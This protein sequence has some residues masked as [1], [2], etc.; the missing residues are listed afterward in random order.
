MSSDP[1][2]IRP[3]RTED[4]ATFAR[5]V[6]ELGVDDPTPS[7]ERY[8]DEFRATMLIADRAGHPVG[9]AF[10][11]LLE[12]VGYVRMVVSAP[13]ARRSG[14]GKALMQ[15]LS[16]RFLAG[17]AT[18]WCLNV[19]PDNAPAIGLYE[20]LGMRRVHASAALRLPWRALATL[21]PDPA[22]VAPDTLASAD[23][24][25]VGAA[26][27][28]PGG[29]LAQLRS[30]GRVLLK[31][32][33]L[34]TGEPAGVAAFDPAFPGAFPFR[35]LRPDYAPVLLRAMRHHATPDR[36][37]VQLVIEDDEPLVH[38]LKAAGA[39]VHLEFFHYRG[40]LNAP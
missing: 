18:T 37:W 20:A 11:Q 6:P 26:L 32:R 36:D 16:R 29:L 30:H 4:Y 12:D 14:V 13:E 38:V 39:A 8:E 10:F 33:S 28:L 27:R 3:A 24:T 25:S 40:P 7:A 15:A 17:G 35:V 31:L 22:E 34:T 19:K 9:C 23:D 21:P 1:I 2:T 5:L